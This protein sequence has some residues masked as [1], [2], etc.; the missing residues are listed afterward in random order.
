MGH[1]GALNS[2]VNLFRWPHSSI[3]QSAVVGWS[4]NNFFTVWTCHCPPWSSSEVGQACELQRL[5][6]PLIYSSIP[7]SGCRVELSSCPLCECW[8]SG[9]QSTGSLCWARITK[10]LSGFLLQLEEDNLQKQ[11]LKG[12]VSTKLFTNG[13]FHPCSLACL[14]FSVVLSVWMC[15]KLHNHVQVL[16]RAGSVCTASGEPSDPG[17]SPGPYWSVCHWILGFLNFLLKSGFSFLIFELDLQ[18]GKQKYRM[19]PLVF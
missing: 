6:G 8:S 2:V 13:S 18:A 14:W 5:R 17:E 1:S 11:T 9:A 12:A 3:L 19:L 15:S 10:G 4:S 7:A 16:L